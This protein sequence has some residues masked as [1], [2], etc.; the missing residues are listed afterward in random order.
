MVTTGNDKC[1]TTFRPVRSQ[2]LVHSQ[3]KIIR[4]KSLIGL[5]SR[6][7][8]I[9]SLFIAYRLTGHPQYREWA[10]NSFLSITN[11]AEYRV[12]GDPGTKNVDVTLEPHP[13]VPSI[14]MEWAEVKRAQMQRERNGE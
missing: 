10:W 1:G 7:E 14:A 3:T 11:N 8:T 6:P 5:P 13:P 12:A 2:V 9:E 4:E